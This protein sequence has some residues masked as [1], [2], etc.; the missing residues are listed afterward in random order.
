MISNVLTSMPSMRA[1]PC[2]SR[3]SKTLPGLLALVMIAS[4]RRSGTMSRKNP[5]RL[6]AVSVDCTARPRQARDIAA[7][8]R[9][10]RGRED[11]RDGRRGLLYRGDYA[12]RCDNDIDFQRD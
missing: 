2:A 8:D 9:I 10:E 11:D 5:S 12:P 1:A 3:I 6:P 4:R 7:R